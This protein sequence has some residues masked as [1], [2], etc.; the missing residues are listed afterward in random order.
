[1]R[2]VIPAESISRNEGHAVVEPVYTFAQRAHKVSL[3]QNRVLS[4]HGPTKIAA[5]LSD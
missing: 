3:F 2:R 4:T 5:R 1:M